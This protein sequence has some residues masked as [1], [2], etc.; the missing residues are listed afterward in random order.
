MSSVSFKDCVYLFNNSN[1]KQEALKRKTKRFTLL[2]EAREAK[3][4]ERIR[5]GLEMRKRKDAM[6]NLKNIMQN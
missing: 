5:L 2:K 1:K 3:R 4:K 6:K